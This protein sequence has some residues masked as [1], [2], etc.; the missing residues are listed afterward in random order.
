[1]L[2]QVRWPLSYVQRETLKG[3]GGDSVRLS[4][5]RAL[6]APRKD[7]EHDYHRHHDTDPITPPGAI[8]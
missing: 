7:T 5:H 3:N 1:M 8:P 6:G 4:S 2:K